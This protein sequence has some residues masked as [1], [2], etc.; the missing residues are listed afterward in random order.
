M[1]L[2]IQNP[3]LRKCPQRGIILFVRYVAVLEIIIE[4]DEMRFLAFPYEPYTMKITREAV[5]QQWPWVL[6]DKTQKQLH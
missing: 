2:Y 3:S 6:I 1:L 5:L 4:P